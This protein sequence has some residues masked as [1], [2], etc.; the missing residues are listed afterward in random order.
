M[1]NIRAFRAF[2][3]FL[4]I[5]PVACVVAVTWCSATAQAR[6]SAN[7]GYHNPP[8]ALV[9]INTMKEWKNFA[10]EAGIGW[11]DADAVDS[12]DKE[13]E[14]KETDTATLGL[15][16]GINGK[17]LFNGSKVRPYLQAGI[18]SAVGASIGKQTGLGANFGGVYGG[19]GLFIGGK[20]VYGFLS[21]NI[22]GSRMFLQAGLG[23][24]L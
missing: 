9:G 13:T 7:L 5:L 21:G 20:D 18:G 22:M 4:A 16:G 1:I 10:F 3:A 15:A 11:I 19:G 17:Y 6:W 2:R 12:D 23:M 14:D 24:S 8:I